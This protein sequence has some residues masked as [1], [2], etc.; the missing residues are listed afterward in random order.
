MPTSSRSPARRGRVDPGV[1]HPRRAELGPSR[2][3]PGAHQRRARKPR[4]CRAFS[5]SSTRTCRRRAG[6]WSTASCPSATARGGAV[7]ARRAQGRDRGPQ[8]GARRK[9]MEQ[10][11]RNAEEALDRRLAETHDPG[12]DPARARRTLRAGRGAP[13]DRGLRQQPHH[14]H[15][16]ARRDDRRRARGLP[17]EQYRKFNIKRPERRPATTSG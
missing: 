7:G 2:L 12:Q 11:K 4:C 16:R 15:Q 3:L 14:G 6:S 5:S 1:L 10:A 8:R 9:L 13:A 17:Q